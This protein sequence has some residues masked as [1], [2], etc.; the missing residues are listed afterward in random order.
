MAV[1][2]ELPGMFDVQAAQERQMID[3]AQLAGQL[4]LGGGMMFASS[5]MG[6]IYNQG[7]MGLAEMM[8][9]APDPATAKQQKI[10]EIMERFP[11]PETA[12]DFMKVY[13]ALNDAGIYDFAGQIFNMASELSNQKT[14]RMNA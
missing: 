14:N 12:N 2:V 1:S 3:D 11:N 8:G 5:G 10:A 7:L 4:P 6:D 13:H 9:G